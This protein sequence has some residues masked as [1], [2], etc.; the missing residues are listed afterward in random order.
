[1]R[2]I[3]GLP[4]G[5]QL[6]YMHVCLFFNSLLPQLVSP[7]AV[8]VMA[9]T[10]AALRRKG[11]LGLLDPEVWESISNPTWMLQ[12]WPRN[13]LKAQSTNKKMREQTSNDFYS[14]CSACQGLCGNI[15]INLENPTE[16]AREKGNHKESWM[17]MGRVTSPSRLWVDKKI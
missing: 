3:W 7:Q 17:S 9:M 16:R 6:F 12:P 10:M 14:R 2:W 8:E 15:K 13:Q 11:V 4:T 5:S 1:M